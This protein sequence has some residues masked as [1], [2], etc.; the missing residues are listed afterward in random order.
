MSFHS[1]FLIMVIH[2][3]SACNLRMV[4]VSAKCKLAFLRTLNFGICLCQ[5]SWFKWWSDGIRRRCLPV[6]FL[7]WVSR[8]WLASVVPSWPR[9]RAVPHSMIPGP[10]I[11]CPSRSWCWPSGSSVVPG[12]LGVEEWSGFVFLCFWW[13]RRGLWRCKISAS[14]WCPRSYWTV[15]YTH[16]TLP[17][18][19]YV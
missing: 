11:M 19:P 18:T 9:C 3:L 17:T 5:L 8:C 7:G 16:L 10:W 13:S 12:S 14:T 1:L 15:S 6:W 4:N 2:S